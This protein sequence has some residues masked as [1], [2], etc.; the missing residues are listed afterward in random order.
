M[1]ESKIKE[2][3]FDEFVKNALN[4]KLG[5]IY[6]NLRHIDLTLMFIYISKNNLK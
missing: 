1:T 3:K 4:I 2:F 5:S 6:F